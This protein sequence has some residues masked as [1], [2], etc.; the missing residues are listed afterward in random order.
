MFGAALGDG[1][2]PGPTDNPELKESDEVTI[3]A[4]TEFRPHRY[5]AVFGTVR[6]QGLLPFA[7][8]MT[9]RD[10]LL[11][12]GGL[13]DDTYLVEV[14]VSRLREIA[15]NPNGDSLALVLRVPLDSSYVFDPTG[16]VR[17]PIGSDTPADMI[18]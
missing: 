4:T 7:D 13:L 18:L 2:N 1:I 8:S 16:Y 3:F 15:G 11:L 10:A 6:N 12:A 9:L 5:V 14:E 17:R